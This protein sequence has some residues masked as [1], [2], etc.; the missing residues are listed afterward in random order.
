MTCTNAVARRIA[1]IAALLAIAL[2]C[3]TGPS[4]A[5][6]M[7]SRPE[8][9]YT[10]Q[11]YIDWM[12]KYAN[13]KP[14]FKPGDV[15]TAK[16]IERMRPFVPPGYLEQLNFPEFKARIVKALPHTPRQ[17]YVNCTEK[18]SA[19]TRLSRDGALLNYVC[20]QP[21]PTDSIST[22]DPMSGYKVAWNYEWKWQNFGLIVM[23]HVWAWV[24]NG[25]TH[26]GTAPQNAESP[27]I[28]W[29]QGVKVTTP[30]PTGIDKLYGGG[31]TYERTL[32]GFYQKT[33]FSHLAQLN[34]GALPAPGSKDFQHKEITIFFN[35]FDIRG[36]AF[37]VYRYLD[38]RRADDSW[39]FI[40]NL[41]RVRRIS[42]EVKSDSL[43]G[44]DLTIEDYY[45]FNGRELDWNWKFLGWK[46]VMGVWDPQDDYAHTYGP[47]GTIADDVWSVKRCAIVLR[48]PVSTRHPYSAV[49]NFFEPETWL[50]P[51]HV[52]FDRKSKL[53]KVFEWR[54]KYSET[55]N[56]WAELNHGIQSYTW[57]SVS[58]ID[59]QNQRA[60]II[61]GFGDGFP[62]YP[63]SQVTSTFDVNRLE[64]VHR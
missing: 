21:F 31:G 17:D 10:V 51:Y 39:A 50:G 63:I 26:L 19:Q 20:G 25:G 48:T 34:G 64:Q 60:T 36:T 59:I 16:D 54:W 5:N 61:R 12:S 2:C 42:A 33:I 14:D 57:Q 58:V 53:W 22:S 18:Y 4:R 49:I 30:F 44:T 23:D 7:N 46:D 28:E 43:L 32:S 27:P 56:H 6:D 13:A 41:R 55:F 24:R 11:T 3:S 1:A 35:P 62:N 8:K 47:N 38:P 29:I 52:A 9:D 15:L 37:I 40:P 45:G